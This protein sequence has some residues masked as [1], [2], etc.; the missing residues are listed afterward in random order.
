MPMGQRGVPP[1]TKGIK[2]NEQNHHKATKAS[3]PNQRQ[4]TQ[5]SLEAKA[6]FTDPLWD[7]YNLWVFVYFVYS[8][9]NDEVLK[10]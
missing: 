7:I 10:Y 2:A 9:S 5:T 4:G 1:T 3:A 8:K 6:D